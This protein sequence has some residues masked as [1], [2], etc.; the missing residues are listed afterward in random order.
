MKSSRVSQPLTLNW[1]MHIFWLLKTLTG[2]DAWQLSSSRRLESSLKRRNERRYF[3]FQFSN[4]GSIIEIKWKRIWT[5]LVLVWSRPFHG[6]LVRISRND[7]SSESYKNLQFS[8]SI[9]NWPF[10]QLL[11]FM[12]IYLFKT[13]FY[14]DTDSIIFGIVWL[15]LK[16]CSAI[17]IFTIISMNYLKRIFRKNKSRT[18]S[19]GKDSNFFQIALYMIHVTWINSWLYFD[20]F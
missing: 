13:W 11:V 14:S 20:G 16:I 18:I 10:C 9:S 12:L 15:K 19:I 3:T 5:L 8:V 6:T 1:R 17:T 4:W 2:R 7:S